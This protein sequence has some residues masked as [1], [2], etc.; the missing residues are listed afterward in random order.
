MGKALRHTVA[1]GGVGEVIGCV[2]CANNTSCLCHTA[3]IASFSAVAGYSM[4]VWANIEQ[5]QPG[6]TEGRLLC[7]TGFDADTSTWPSAT[8][9]GPE[10]GVVPSGGSIKMMGAFIQNGGPVGSQFDYA[11]NLGTWHNLM[12]TYAAGDVR[13]YVDGTLRSTCTGSHGPLLT[14]ARLGLCCLMWLNQQMISGGPIGRYANLA[15]W[16]RT[17]AASDVARVAASIDYVPKNADHRYNMSINGGVIADV[18]TVGGWDFTTLS[19]F[20]NSVIE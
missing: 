6:L 12:V 14:N 13:T 9:R 10:L 16:Y 18:G 20:E 5:S 19:G 17:L 11:E 2:R 15:F 8:T 4:S 7:V 1:A 3:N